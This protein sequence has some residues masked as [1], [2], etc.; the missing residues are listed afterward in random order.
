MT[1]KLYQKLVKNLT[2]KETKKFN[3]W[4][5]EFHSI[6]IA[7]VLSE[8][9]DKELLQF[10]ELTNYENMAIILEQ[11]EEKTQVRLLRLIELEDETKLF[12]Q[13]STDNLTD[14][15][16]NL[17]FKER[18]ELLNRMKNN[19]SGPVSNLL[20]YDTESAGGL[21]TTEYIALNEG[22]TI[23]QV[24]NKIKTIGITTE[25]IDTIYVLNDNKLVG[26]AD[27]RNI[28]AADEKSLLRDVTDYNVVSVLPNDDQEEISLLVAKYDLTAIPVVNRKDQLLGIITVDDIIDVIETE[29]TEDM[30]RMV[31]VSEEESVHSSLKNSI[32]KRLPWLIINLATAFLASFTVGL[33]E[34]IIAQVVALAAAMPI[35]AGMG[36]NAG[37]QTLSVVIR[38]IALGEIDLRENWRFVFKEIGLGLINGAVTGLLTGIILYFQYGNPYLGL[39]I[40]LAMIGNLLIAGL[41]GFLIPLFLELIGVDPALASAIF[42]TTATDV[43]GFFIFL[44]LAKMMLGFI[45]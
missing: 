20:G 3:A 44:G 23:A 41:A 33:F 29:N 38:G 28:L 31:G 1:G 42:V 5:E 30:F 19:K 17:P 34:D 12:S 15:M 24:L 43:F 25:V 4:L 32:K 39:I 6:D 22:L 36:G 45:S 11:A 35:V 26:I 10:Y 16:G 40:F 21:M 8:L 27:L 14:I 2:T 7:E 37:T 18:K 9:S 13:M